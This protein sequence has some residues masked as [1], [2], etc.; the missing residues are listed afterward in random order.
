MK[1][2]STIKI[3]AYILSWSDKYFHQSAYGLCIKF[4]NERIIK[5]FSLFKPDKPIK[6]YRGINKYNNE[7]EGIISWTYKK[8]IA[9]NYIKE[10]GKIIERIFRPEEILLDT[11][12]LKQD[13]KVLLGYDYEID[14]EEVL[15]MKK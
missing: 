14:D 2:V 10:E 3:P 12:Y 15:T 4:P 8:E 13:Q 6:L 1:N 5:F 9:E 7:T 11:T